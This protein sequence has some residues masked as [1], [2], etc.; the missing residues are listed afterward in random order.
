[1]RR[2]PPYV[3]HQGPCKRRRCLATW[4]CNVIALKNAL[5]A[6]MPACQLEG[7]HRTVPLGV[8]LRS[9]PTTADVAGPR[10]SP[11][12]LPGC[13]PLLGRP[14]GHWPHVAPRR[15]S[16]LVPDDQ[17]ALNGKRLKPRSRSKLHAPA[18]NAYAGGRSSANHHTGG[19]SVGVVNPG[20]LHSS[21]RRCR[22]RR[23]RPDRLVAVSRRVLRRRVH[24]NVCAVASG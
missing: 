6:S 18:F 17:A 3:S 1:M 9:Q 4:L 7:E 23:S 8:P 21:H 11:T 5:P 16:A 15:L 20:K 14:F 24:V 22:R 13:P 19:G 12:P 2:R 10:S